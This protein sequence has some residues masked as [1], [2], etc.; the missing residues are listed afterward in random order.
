MTKTDT[1]GSD[2]SI[3]KTSTGLADRILTVFNKSELSH[4]QFNCNLMLA[5]LIILNTV[6]VTNRYPKQDLG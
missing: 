3:Y 5:Q 1:A 6:L 2:K 4:F